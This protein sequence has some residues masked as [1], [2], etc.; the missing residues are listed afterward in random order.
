MVV[1]VQKKIKGKWRTVVTVNSIDA[2]Q[3]YDHLCKQHCQHKFRISKEKTDDM[4][5]KLQGL[6]RDEALTAVAD[7]RL[8][9]LTRKQSQDTR[10]AIANI[11]IQVR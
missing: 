6:S 1:Y 5:V 3:V 11:I 7:L 8:V 9:D 10:Q 2:Q 4:P